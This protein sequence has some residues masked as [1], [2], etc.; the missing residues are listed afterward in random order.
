MSISSA[1]TN[2]LTGLTAAAR[3]ADVVSANVANALTPG[4]GRREVQISAMSLGG[5]GAGVRVDG[6][7]RAVNAGV[8]GDRRLADAETGNADLRAQALA[9]IEGAIGDPTSDG[10]LSARLGNLEEALILAAARPDSEARLQSVADSAAI[11][12]GMLADLTGQVQDIRMDADQEIARQVGVLNTSLR[13]IDELNADILAQR[14]AGRDATALMDQRQ[15]LVDQ[16]ARIVPLRE[17][18][19]DHDQIALF[20]TGGAI[21]LEGNPAE[22]GFAPVGVIT[23]DMTLQSGALSGLTVNGMQIPAGKAAPCG[24]AVWVRYSRSGMRSRPARRPSS[25]HLRAT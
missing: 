15:V 24:A 10:S 19:R 5:N 6:V 9:R 22:I 21:L 17:V 18:P 23:A 20:T 1:L 25:T 12:A 16:V 8:I 13:Q 4:Y 2:A 14:S 11:L 7:T 3:R